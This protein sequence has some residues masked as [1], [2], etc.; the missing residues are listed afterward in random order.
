MK[1]ILNIFIALNIL[2][3]IVN[4]LNLDYDDITNLEKNRQDLLNISLC[5]VLLSAF[6]ISK[7]KRKLTT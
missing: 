1:I 5:L 6:V 7:N 2:V 3:L 4:V